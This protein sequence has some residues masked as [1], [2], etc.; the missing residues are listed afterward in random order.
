MLQKNFTLVQKFLNWE[1]YF[2]TFILHIHSAL[3]CF[4]ILSSQFIFKSLLIITA[5]IGIY[6]VAWCYLVCNI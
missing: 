6:D 3:P 5:Q 4:K 1:F 2:F